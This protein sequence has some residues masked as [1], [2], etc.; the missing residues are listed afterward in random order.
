MA[1]I[2]NIGKDKYLTVDRIWRDNGKDPEYA[3]VGGSKVLIDKGTKAK[4]V[5]C[6]YGATFFYM[7]GSPVTEEKDVDHLPEPFRTTALKFIRKDE[8]EG[9]KVVA[10]KEEA[11]AV[12]VAPRKRGRP[13]KKDA[14]KVEAKIEIK[15]EESY[16]RA[17]GV[18]I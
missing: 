1:S 2:L 14:A 9:A 8:K 16:R 18:V 13:S 4:P 11:V 5:I 10:S 15:D 6:Q 7:D 3:L 12:A 17:G